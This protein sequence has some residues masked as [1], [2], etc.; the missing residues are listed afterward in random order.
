M[1]SYEINISSNIT[2]VENKHTWQWMNS[3]ESSETIICI[4]MYE[5]RVNSV[6]G[7]NPM[8]KAGILNSFVNSPV[9]KHHTKLLAFHSDIDLNK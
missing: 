3:T 2:V 9:S 1:P 6:Q 5:G 7:I 4:E 8:S